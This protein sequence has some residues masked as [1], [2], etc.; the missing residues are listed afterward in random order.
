MTWRIIG[1]TALYHW[2]PD[3]PRIPL[4]ID[5]LTPAKIAGSDSKICIV[6]SHWHDAAEELIS[7]NSDPVFLDPDLLLTMKV[8]HAQW[9]IKWNKTM[10]DIN[11][12][13]S[14]GCKI[15]E[16]AFKSLFDAWSKIHG[17][18][19]VNMSQDMDAFFDDAVF[20]KYDHEKLHELIAFNDRPMHEHIRP[21]LTRAWC[22]HDL[23]LGLSPE[24]Q[25]NCALEEILVIAIERNHLTHTS[26]NSDK[27]RAVSRA[28]FQLIT[29]MT[30]GWFTRFLILNHINI[31]FTRKTQWMKQLNNTLSFLQN[32]NYLTQQN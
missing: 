17:S 3:F 5:L 22:S 30:T 15:N 8:S 32:Q 23:F 6:D 20:R 18:K 1:S 12:L 26:K 29:S 25:I 19:K 7:F 28:Y 24:D 9:D 27:M 11:F 4:D 13:L 16:V 21:D 31:I 2:Y 14:K 10:W